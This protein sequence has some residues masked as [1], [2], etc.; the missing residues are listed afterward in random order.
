MSKKVLLDVDPGCDDSVLIAFMLAHDDVDVVGISTVA[1]NTTL[2]NTTRNALAVLEHFDRSDIPVASGCHRPLVSELELAEWVHGP[3]GLRGNLSD[4]DI[5]PI[6]MHGTEF[7]IEQAQKY[8]DDLTI[9]AVGPQ[10]NLAVALAQ[11]PD[12]QELVNDIYQM[13]GAALTAGNTTPTAEFN[14]YNDPVAASRVIQDG[15]PRMVGLDV[16]NRATVPMETIDEFRTMDEPLSVVG[17]WLDYP[18]E[19]SNGKAI[20]IHDAAVG[21]DIVADILEFEEYY[22]EIDTTNGPSRGTV[23]CDVNNVREDDPN[24]KVAVDIDTKRF[25]SEL[26]ETLRSLE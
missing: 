7:I 2:K 10:T 21:V 24:A 11:E 1:G 5:K 6:E 20:S 25:K 26:L 16:T 17:D 8:G 15:S 3:D 13:G 14:F 19:I 23:V 18:D 22:L 12:L 9:A 4:P